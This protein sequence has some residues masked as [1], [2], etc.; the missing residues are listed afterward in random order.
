MRFTLYVRDADNQEVT[1]DTPLELFDRVMNMANF[2]G[3][4]AIDVTGSRTVLYGGSYLGNA[5]EGALWEDARRD[6]LEYLE[7]KIVEAWT[8]IKQPHKRQLKKQR[9][10]RG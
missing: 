1:A 9:A 6:D 7:Q 3:F 4:W 2:S 8:C 5:Y 10:K